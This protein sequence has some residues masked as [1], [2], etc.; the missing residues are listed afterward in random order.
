MK[1][2]ILDE[3]LPLG[4]YRELTEEELKKLRKVQ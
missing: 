1:D 3:N 4:K 2:L